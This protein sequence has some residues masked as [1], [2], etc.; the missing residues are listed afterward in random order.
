[1]D[2][3]A[4]FRQTQD[5][6]Y[7]A[8]LTYYDIDL[9]PTSHAASF[10]DYKTCDFHVITA[11]R[12]LSLP[13]SANLTAALIAFIEPDRSRWIKVAGGVEYFA[14]VRQALWSLLWPMEIMMG[15]V[16]AAG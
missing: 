2:A 15:R 4:H 9:A 12:E 1:L 8:K 11:R 7:L 5:D 6:L 13:Q 14:D 10:R 16:L 3:E